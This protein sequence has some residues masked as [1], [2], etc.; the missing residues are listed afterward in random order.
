M[1]QSV[2]SQRVRHNL[3]RTNNNLFAVFYWTK[4]S[5]CKREYRIFILWHHS[6]VVLKTYSFLVIPIKNDEILQLTTVLEKLKTIPVPIHL[7]EDQMWKHEAYLTCMKWIVTSF[8][9]INLFILIGDPLLYNIVLILPYVNINLPR[10]YTCSPSWTPLPPP[11]PYH[12]SGSSQCTSPKHP[13]PA[14][15]L[16]WQFVSYMIFY[17]FQCHSPKSSH[18]LPLPQNQKDS[19]IHLCLFCCLAY[20]V[21]VTIFLHFIYIR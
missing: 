9:N 5:F 17:M 14:S 19:S 20:R 15:N 10:V 11:S 4:F 18:P 1:Q 2:G 16:D 21:I 12:P 6:I 13:V 7:V 8:F 3:Q